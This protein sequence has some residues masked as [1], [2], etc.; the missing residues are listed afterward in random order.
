MLFIGLA[1]AKLTVKECSWLQ[2]H[3]VA[4]VVLFKRNIVSIKQVQ[5]L[6]ADLREAAP[7]PLIIAVDQE[8][9]RV[10]RLVDGCTILPPLRSLGDLYSQNAE[11][12]RTRARQL[13]Y[14]MA[15]EVHHN[16][17]D[18]SF[19]PVVDVPV[20]GCPIGD[21]ALSDEAQCVAEL[22]CA[23]V[24]GMHEANMPAILKHF[25]GHGGV[26]ADTHYAQAY[27]NR[28]WAEIEARDLLPFVRAIQAGADA[29]MMSHVIYPQLD[30]EI[31]GCSRYWIQTVLREKVGFRGLIFSDD[32]G[33]A[34][35]QRQGGVAQRVQA[36]WDAGCDVVL[37]CHPELVDD[38]LAA[39]EGR[40]FNTAPLLGLLGRGVLGWDGVL[41]HHAHKSGLPPGSI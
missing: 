2:H 41:A 33:M 11:A 17:V 10:Q 3:A 9:G 38:A 27:D 22:A 29:V 35:A 14:L 8:G 7:R 13:A 39:T 40:R 32:I 16:G 20:P 4:G 1:G 6:S 25:P 36:H 28:S 31:A 30:S 21:R 5:R 19:A 26:T 24:Q 23:Y 18:W 15:S 12:A 34:A 37:V